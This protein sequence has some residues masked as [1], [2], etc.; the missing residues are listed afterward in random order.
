VLSTVEA[1]ARPPPLAPAPAPAPGPGPKLM[2]ARGPAASTAPQPAVKAKQVLQ[3]CCSVGVSAGA[4]T[5]G[6]AHGTERA[7]ATE[8]AKLPEALWLGPHLVRV[9]AGLTN[10]ALTN[11]SSPN[12]NLRLGPHLVGA[13]LLRG[14]HR[15]GAE[16]TIGRAAARPRHGR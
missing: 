6:A 1:A 12:P 5:A 13:A 2:L 9:R 11:P 7:A 15:E 3:H 4:A 8:G 14:R 10:P 16:T